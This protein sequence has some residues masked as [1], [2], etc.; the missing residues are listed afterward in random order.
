[1]T[2]RFCDQEEAVWSAMRNGA[3]TEELRIHA[4]SCPICAELMLVAEYLHQEVAADPAELRVPDAD[5]VWLKARNRAR[6]L[7]VARAT[8]PIR[9]V[10]IGAYAAALLAAAWFVP[11]LRAGSWLPAFDFRYLSAMDRA[12][13]MTLT[14]TMAIGV[15]ASLICISFGSWYV[16]RQE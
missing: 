6:E 13:S 4:G 2:N 16:L 12:G 15:V 7:A 3:L 11:F 10:R 1:M 9:V 14:G 5:F 8:L